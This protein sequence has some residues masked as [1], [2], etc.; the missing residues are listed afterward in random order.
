[1]AWGGDPKNYRGY[2]S[3]PWE[4]R[5]SYTYTTDSYSAEEDYSDLENSATTTEETIGALVALERERA[6]ETLRRKRELVEKTNKT[7]KTNIF[8]LFYCS[9]CRCFMYAVFCEVK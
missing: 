4:Y 8:I 5:K 6:A 9:R 7:N 3:S 1:M 2:T